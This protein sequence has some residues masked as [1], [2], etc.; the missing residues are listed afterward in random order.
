MAQPL[1][2]VVMPTYN[3]AQFIKEAI[4]SVLSQSYRNMELIVI[5]NYSQD[6][7]RQIVESFGDPRIKYHQFANN[8][9]I[10]ASRN[11][12]ITQAQGEYVA[13]IDSDDVWF[14][15]KLKLQMEALCEDE[16]SKDF[17]QR[18]L[19]THTLQDTRRIAHIQNKR[20]IAS[21]STSNLWGRVEAHERAQEQQLHTLAFP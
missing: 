8:G 18:Q 6:N 4:E 20:P 14:G 9:I 21:L 12:G 1:V 7:T 2:S 3:H 16:E 19:L 5:D 11:Y 15:D 17:H 10:A 13:F